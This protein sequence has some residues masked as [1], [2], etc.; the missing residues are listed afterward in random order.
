MV[1]AEQT[2]L[3]A[4]VEDW[5]QR[6]RVSIAHVVKFGR[7]ARNTIWLIQ[8]GTTTEPEAET[9][10]K[11]ARGIAAEPRTGHVDR[12]IYLEVLQDL[13]RAAGMPDITDGVPPADLE[14]E[15]RAAG[16]KGKRAAI[17]AAFVRKYPHMDA[18]DKRLVDALL[19]RMGES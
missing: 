3:A 2:R 17:L 12:A 14:S 15:I 6:Q 7:V 9:L 4:I 13:G 5:F 19:D 10:R 16:V 11:I 1:V 18:A 8:Q